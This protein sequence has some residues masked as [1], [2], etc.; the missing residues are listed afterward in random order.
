MRIHKIADLIEEAHEIFNAMS[1]FE[2]IDLERSEAK[3]LLNQKYSFP[4]SEQVER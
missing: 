2:V 1:I 3:E 4:E